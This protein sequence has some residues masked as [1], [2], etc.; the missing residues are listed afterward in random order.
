MNELISSQE[1]E[2]GRRERNER[3]NDRRGTSMMIYLL[4]E[5]EREKL[6]DLGNLSLSDDLVLVFIRSV[7]ENPA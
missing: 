6:V 3:I 4:S 5:R 2:R 7:R 1:W